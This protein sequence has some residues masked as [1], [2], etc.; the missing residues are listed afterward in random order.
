MTRVTD[1]IRTPSRVSRPGGR[2][3]RANQQQLLW[4]S[5]LL[6]VPV[7][8][9]LYS[10]VADSTL[11][12]GPIEVAEAA[13]EMAVDGELLQAAGQSGLVFLTGIAAGTAVGLAIGIL[14][15]RF[16]TMDVMLDPYI[17]ALFATPL[18][19]V[20]PILIVALGFG[21]GA[22]VVIVAMFAFFPVAINTAAGVRGIPREFDELA[23]SF[24]SSE[25]QAWRDILVPGAL[26]YIVTGLRLA[27]GRSL[28][29]VVVAEFS[30]A[31]T[32]LGF[33]ILRYSRRFDMAESLVPV[34]LLML[35]GFVFYTLLKRVEARL[36]PW[37]LRTSE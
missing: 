10:M 29:A 9:Q 12:V 20:V 8:W 15:G 6:I 18:V 23:R 1:R 2:R 16:R 25:L 33:L 31:V 24:C 17:S 37:I 13:V 19:A 11:I 14:V 36:A 7:I 3:G 32:G 5:G 35:T 34:V 28:I 26:P 4:W 21:F 27:V 22:K 30:T